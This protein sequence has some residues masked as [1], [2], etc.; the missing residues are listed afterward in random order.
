MARLAM[1]AISGNRQGTDIS[2]AAMTALGANTGVSF[3]NSGAM[4]LIVNNGAG[5][6]ITVTLTSVGNGPDGNAATP[7]TVSVPAGKTYAIG[8]MSRS[9]YLSPDGSGNTYIDFSSSTSV[10]VLLLQTPTLS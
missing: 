2:T 5:A 8:P 1:T 9:A 7:P 6:P 4:E 3:Q 10:S